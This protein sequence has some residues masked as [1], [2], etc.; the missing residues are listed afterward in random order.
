VYSFEKKKMKIAQQ[1]LGHD[2]PVERDPD[3]IG[4]T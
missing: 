1:R 3:E 4:S 2:C